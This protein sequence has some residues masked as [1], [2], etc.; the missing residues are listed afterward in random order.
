MLVPAATIEQV[1]LGKDGRV[2]VF[3]AA[4]SQIAKD[5]EQLAAEANTVFLLR[6]H[7]NTGHY[8][9]IQRYGP[10]DDDEQLVATCVDKEFLPLVVTEVR[11]MVRTRSYDLA[12]ELDAHAAATDKANDRETA[13]KA[14][15]WAQRN[16]SR[17]RRDMGAHT[18]R[19]SVPA[20]IPKPGDGA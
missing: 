19:I 10:A 2:H 20:A 15:E 8:S 18:D 4:E 3:S 11:R 9:V 6:W 12:A 5:L 14:G 16:W 1:R 17:M 7:E 13:E